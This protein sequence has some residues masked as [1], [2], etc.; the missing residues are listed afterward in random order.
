M[1]RITG[2]SSAIYT[3]PDPATTPAQPAAATPNTHRKRPRQLHEREIEHEHE[4]EQ[5]HEV[6][7]QEQL[8]GRRKQLA[9]LAKRIRR[10]G[11]K[12]R[13]SAGSADEAIVETNSDFEDLLMIMEEHAR[14]SKPLLVG[15]SKQGNPHDGQQGRRGNNPQSDLA[16]RHA[17]L[18]RYLLE[19]EAEEAAKAAKAAEAGEKEK[20]AS[21]Q[22][23]SASGKGAGSAA[24]AL[25]AQRKELAA[26]L[27]GTAE[28][29]TYKMLLAELCALLYAVRAGNTMPLRLALNLSRAFI[30]ASPLAGAPETLLAVKKDLVASVPP[31]EHKARSEREEAFHLLLPLMLLSASLP[32]TSQM[33][34]E[35]YA[36]SGALARRWDAEVWSH[37]AGMAVRPINVSA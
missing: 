32:R 7:Y 22:A 37:Q 23:S 16:G 26:Q 18:R 35:G 10:P 33:K 27:T 21:A 3:L 24:P 2:P 28:I 19:A 9:K 36:R 8:T 12:R 34:S 17:M 1:T 5:E 11:S 15:P 30:K 14:L 25:S 31:A 20:A 29:P 6:Q 13:G 4:H